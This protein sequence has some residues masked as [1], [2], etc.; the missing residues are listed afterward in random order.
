[1]R[2][3]IIDDSAVI[4]KIIEGALRQADLHVD[5]VLHAG[6][7]LEGLAVLEAAKAAGAA[8]DLILSDVHMP[9]MDGLAFL[10]ERKQRNLAP[11]VPV[12]MITADGTDPSVARALAAGAQGY[13]SKPFTLAEIQRRVTSLLAVA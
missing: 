10:L 1:M 8:I 3:L 2:V 11:D 9:I 5:T 12:V 4:R 7:G 13:I 6:N